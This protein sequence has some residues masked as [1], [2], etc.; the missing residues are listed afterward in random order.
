[1]SG[2][3]LAPDD[4]A[5]LHAFGQ[6]LRLMRARRGMTRRALAGQSGVSE[7]YLAQLEAGRGNASVSVLRALARAFGADP[8]DLIAEQPDPPPELGRLLGLVR[9]LAPPQ[10]VAARRLLETQLLPDRERRERIA[11]IGLR[12][13]GKSTLGPL[14]AT[15][16]GVPFFE[17]DREVERSAGMGL[18]EI[19]ELHGQAGFRRLERGA[20]EALLARSGGLVVAVG[21]SVVA[22]P[23][24]FA[25]LLGACRTVWIRATPAEHMARVVA[26]GDLRP[27]ADTR[28]A[29]ADLRAILASREALYAQADLVLD[30]SARTVADSA[31]ELL[32]RL[33]AP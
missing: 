18:A 14:I 12:G 32:A 15:A 3:R 8:A 24:N 29:M 28:E 31:R 7:R 22:E 13:A 21:G 11:L 20:L 9:R 26:Q 2:H 17:L 10:I 33:A 6:R 30:N 1:M 16:R 25:L 23:G 4:A 5:F 19:F 27:M